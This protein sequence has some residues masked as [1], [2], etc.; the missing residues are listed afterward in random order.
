MRGPGP[1]LARGVYRMRQNVVHGFAPEPT[2]GTRSMTNG[3]ALRKS[4][5]PANLDEPSHAT[6]L[7]GADFALLRV[8]P[9]AAR[10]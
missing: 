6:D 1:A 3:C 7:V 4:R 8:A 9:T 5:Q 2:N 10:S